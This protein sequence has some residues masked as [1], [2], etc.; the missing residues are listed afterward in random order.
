MS[1]EEREYDSESWRVR[2]VRPNPDPAFRGVRGDKFNKSIS[3]SESESESV[4]E[5]DIDEVNDDG[6]GDGEG[7]GEGEND[8][9]CDIGA[10]DVSLTCQRMFVQRGKID[11]GTMLFC[12]SRWRCRMAVR[13][14]KWTVLVEGFSCAY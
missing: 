2:L 6:D 9:D 5:D 8:E 14:A 13:G 12:E 3:G 10:R 1:A 4:V 7:E 11:A